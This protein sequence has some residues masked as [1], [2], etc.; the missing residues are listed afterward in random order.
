MVIESEGNKHL[1]EL[2]LTDEIKALGV[3]RVITANDY[4][5]VFN[6][7]TF[8]ES[9]HYKGDF[10]K[11]LL[12]LCDRMLNSG[13]FGDQKT[14]EKI[15]LLISN[16][17]AD[18]KENA[19]SQPQQPRQPVT[20]KDIKFVLATMTKEAPYDGIAIKQL[21]YGMCSA[22]TK[23]PI[24]HSVNSRKAGSGK[25]YILIRINF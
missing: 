3:S 5:L 17:Y 12:E 8:A 20:S 1:T 22:F 4:F 9:K 23:L 25:T 14:I 13:G 24:H 19:A 16:I 2:K 15:V 11:T 10:E 18:E 21:F 7:S 6:G